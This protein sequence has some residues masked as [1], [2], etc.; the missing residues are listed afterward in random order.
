[1]NQAPLRVAARRKAMEIASKIEGLP[2]DGFLYIP[3]GWKDGMQQNSAVLHIVHRT[4]E[5][6]CSFVTC[7]PGSGKEYHLAS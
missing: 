2:L 1:M 5:T 4:S 7:N 6:H 3:G